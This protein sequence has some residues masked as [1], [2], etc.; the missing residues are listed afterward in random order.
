[1]HLLL[2]L[3]VLTAVLLSGCA[4][5][6]PQ[7]Y[8]S[9]DLVENVPMS[10]GAIV[11]PSALGQFLANA[12][13]YESTVI[14]GRT[15]VVKSSYFSALGAQCVQYVSQNKELTACNKGDQWVQFPEVAQTSKTV[16]SFSESAQ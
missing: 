9:R 8:A 15:F 5:S 10:Q 16:K 13:P 11:L 1:M 6:P 14:S 7:V 2:R 12:Q 3:V 4:T